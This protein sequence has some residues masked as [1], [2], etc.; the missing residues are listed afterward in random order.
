MSAYEPNTLL[1]DNSLTTMGARLP[2]MATTYFFHP[3]KKV[4]AV[5][6]DALC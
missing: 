1:L 4:V 2:S 5:C 3:K 6:G